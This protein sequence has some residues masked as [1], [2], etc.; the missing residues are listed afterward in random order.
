MID[1]EKLAQLRRVS[2]LMLDVRLMT[3]RRVKKA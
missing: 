3:L 2:Q 1:R